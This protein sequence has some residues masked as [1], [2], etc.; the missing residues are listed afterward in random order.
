M[1]EGLEGITANRLPA[2]PGL[3]IRTF[4]RFRVNDAIT[5]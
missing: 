4:A 5:I 1:P 2:G 3:D